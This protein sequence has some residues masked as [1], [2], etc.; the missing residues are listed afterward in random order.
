MLSAVLRSD[1]AIDMSINII[2]ENHYSEMER[3]ILEEA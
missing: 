2:N 3:L 1:V